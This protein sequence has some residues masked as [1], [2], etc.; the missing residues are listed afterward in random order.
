MSWSNWVRQLARRRM[1]RAI[2]VKMPRHEQCKEGRV[3][4][5]SL[6]ASYQAYMFSNVLACK[7]SIRY[8]YTYHRKGAVFR[9]RRITNMHSPYRTQLEVHQY[10]SKSFFPNTRTYLTPVWMRV[11][12]GKHASKMAQDVPYNRVSIHIPIID[13]LPIL[14]LAMLSQPVERTSLASSVDGYYI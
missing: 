14:L 7:I 9:T 2:V 4:W 13:I 5:T 12:A 8:P 1:L 3:S 11:S 10:H 6:R